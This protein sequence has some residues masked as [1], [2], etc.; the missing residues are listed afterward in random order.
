MLVTNY[1]NGMTPRE[2][3]A[4]AETLINELIISSNLSQ[5]KLNTDL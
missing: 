5:S 1:Y 3:V 2:A 4:Y